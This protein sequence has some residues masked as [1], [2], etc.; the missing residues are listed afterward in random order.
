MDKEKLKK[1]AGYAVMGLVGG[2]LFFFI[3]LGITYD[4][5]SLFSPLEFYAN[6]ADLLIHLLGYQIL[7]SLLGG[8]R[9]KKWWGAFIGGALGIVPIFI[10]FWIAKD[11]DDKKSANLTEYVSSGAK[12]GV[13]LYILSG[14]YLFVTHYSG[15]ALCLLFPL[16]A[17]FL[18]PSVEFSDGLIFFLFLVGFI[19]F[20]VYAVILFYSE[21]FIRKKAT[22]IGIVIIFVIH[23]GV[24]WVIGF[25]SFYWPRNCLYY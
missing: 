15:A 24:V 22:L 10:F 20:P 5:W 8:I 4:K 2:Y 3:L 6:L 25:G 14:G 13:I 16:S 21:K 23:I 19:Q 9:I 17:L 7:G 1:Y 11:K 12:V 18:A